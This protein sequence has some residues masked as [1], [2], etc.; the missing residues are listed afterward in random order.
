M[1]EMQSLAKY[2]KQILNICIPSSRSNSIVAFSFGWE[3][4]QFLVYFL[5][6][7][8]NILQFKKF[9][10]I[11]VI[12][13]NTICLRLSYNAY[14]HKLGT[15]SNKMWYV[16]G[17]KLCCPL[18]E[19]HAD[20]YCFYTGILQQSEFICWIKLSYINFTGRMKKVWIKSLI[21]RMRR[22]SATSWAKIAIFFCI[23]LTD[24]RL[25]IICSM[26]STHVWLQVY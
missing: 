25:Y 5:K 18:F 6:N 13:N 20:F 9:S 16:R 21:D 12:K 7:T 23:Y 3:D 15:F 19:N 2:H 11:H 14:H 24:F 17:Q 26:F 22:T 4:W 10:P 1:V 8:A